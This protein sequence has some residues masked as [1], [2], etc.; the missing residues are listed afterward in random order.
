MLLVL[1]PLIS[2]YWSYLVNG[3]IFFAEEEILSPL[4]LG[5]VKL[6][7]WGPVDQLLSSKQLWQATGVGSPAA[8]PACPSYHSSEREPGYCL[9]SAIMI[10]YGQNLFIPLCMHRYFSKHHGIWRE[11]Y[12]DKYLLVNSGCESLAEDFLQIF[13]F[14]ISQGLWVK[15]LRIGAAILRAPQLFVLAVISFNSSWKIMGKYGRNP[16]LR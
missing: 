6:L 15:R 11:K 10:K 1:L 14:M 9:R 4:L 16:A 8:T 3:F 12:I 7:P 13:F 2:G 5:L